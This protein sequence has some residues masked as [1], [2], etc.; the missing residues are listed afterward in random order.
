MYTYHQ[1][2]LDATTRRLRRAASDWDRVTVH[3]CESVT[4]AV[5]S[6]EALAECPSPADLAVGHRACRAGR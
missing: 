6:R 5:A 3:S 1:F 2:R 4:A